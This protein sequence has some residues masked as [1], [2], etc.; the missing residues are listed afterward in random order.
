MENVRF[1]NQSISQARKLS[2]F[3]SIKTKMKLQYYIMVG[4]VTHNFET[5]KR[6]ENDKLKQNR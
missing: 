5:K 6:S 1:V 4:V 3:M 2:F